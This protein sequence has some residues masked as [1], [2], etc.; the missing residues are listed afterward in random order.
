MADLTDT[1]MLKTALNE[2]LDLRISLMRRCKSEEDVMAVALAFALEAKTIWTHFDGSRC[3]ADQFY[4]LA[5]K[6]VEENYS[7]GDIS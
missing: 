3:A 4:W 2:V 6:C 5:D 1:S 7:C